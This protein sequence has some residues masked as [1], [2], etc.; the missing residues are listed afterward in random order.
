MDNEWCK[1]SYSQ[2]NGNCLEARLVGGVVQVRESEAPEVITTTTPANWA[3]FLD[4]A[5]AGEFD[6]S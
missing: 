6:L 1:S 3:A 5:K 4:G 2:G